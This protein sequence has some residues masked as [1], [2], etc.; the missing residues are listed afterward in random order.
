MTSHPRKQQSL[1]LFVGMRTDT[2]PH[3]G[4]R[5]STLRLIQAEVL[6]RKSNFSPCVP[7]AAPSTPPPPAAA[8]AAALFLKEF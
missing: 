8:A 1:M 5:I 3:T 7:P 6:A 4:H 2:K